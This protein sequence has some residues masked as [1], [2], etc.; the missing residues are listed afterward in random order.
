ME[1]SSLGQRRFDLRSLP[2]LAWRKRETRL[3]TCGLCAAGK[4][5]R[6]YAISRSAWRLTCS[7]ICSSRLGSPARGAPSLGY[8]GACMR[9]G[10]SCS[11]T[12]AEMWNLVRGCRSLFTRFYHT[13]YVKIVKT[14]S[15]DTLFFRAKRNLKFGF[16]R[17]VDLGRR[18]FK[19]KIFFSQACG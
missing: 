3:V 16:D 19:K 5:P 18:F 4:E 2:N 12:R 8:T 13:K 14:W 9:S 15:P 6:A 17:I 10:L 11:L 1:D 7:R